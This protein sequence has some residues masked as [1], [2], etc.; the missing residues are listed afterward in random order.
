MK[1]EYIAL[2]KW[3]KKYKFKLVKCWQYGNDDYETAQKCGITYEEYEHYLGLDDHLREIRDKYVDEL[4]R[5]ARDTVG[6][7]IRDPDNKDHMKASMW[8]L[9]KR[10]PEFG[11]KSRYEEI[12]D[13]DT[14]EEKRKKNKEA[15]DDFMKN[16]HAEGDLFDGNR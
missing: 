14:V 12:K 16:F 15:L 6:A 13:V 7:A 3:L 5:L 11:A 2:D 10:D 1:N 8:Y 9:E 4:R